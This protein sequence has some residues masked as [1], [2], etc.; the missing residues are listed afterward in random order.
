VSPTKDHWQV[1]PWSASEALEVLNRGLVSTQQT[2]CQR[3]FENPCAS[4]F[5]V[6]IRVP[7]FQSINEMSALLCAAPVES[8]LAQ[9][10]AL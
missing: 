4:C 1:G 9:F 7:A 5:C 3:G 10:P 6:E 8:D 2:Q